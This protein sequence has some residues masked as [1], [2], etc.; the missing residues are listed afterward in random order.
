MDFTRKLR[1]SDTVLS[2]EI[3]GEMVLLDTNTEQY[4]GLDTVA[5]DF[6]KLLGEDMTLE[7]TYKELLNIY[8][9]EP[10]ILKKDLEKFVEDILKNDLA[11]LV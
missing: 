3:D 6:W 2:Q 7:K 5:T 10:N 9:V 1:F 11:V 8:E 4:F